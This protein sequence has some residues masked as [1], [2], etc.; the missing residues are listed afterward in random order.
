AGRE[1]GLDIDKIAF[2]PQGLFYTVND[3]DNRLPGSSVPPPPPFTPSGPPI[4]TGKEKFLGDAYSSPQAT[5]FTA[6]W[7][8]VTPENG[9]KWGSVEGTR[10]VMNWND[11]DAAYNVAKTNGFPFKFHTLI[12]G[13]QQP[14]WI[15]TLAPTEQ[16]AEINQWF[17]AVAARYPGLDFIDV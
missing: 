10:D 2:G 7:N 6:Y 14:A 4:A 12:W 17:D 13:N 5:S 9:G 3:L 15:E 1:D 11:L 8:Q 16:L